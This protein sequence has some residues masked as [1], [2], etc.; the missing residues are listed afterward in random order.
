MRALHAFVASGLVFAGLT[1]SA[2]AAPLDV[3]ISNADG[4]SASATYQPPEKAQKQWRIGILIPHLKDTYWLAAAF[5][6]MDEAQR[7]GI[8]AKLVPAQG[9]TDVTGQLNQIDNLVVEQVDA[10]VL[11]AV[12]PQALSQ[13]VDQIVA[14]GIPVIGM[15][16]P[17]DSDAVKAR[18]GISYRIPAAAGGAYLAKLVGD[19]NANVA[20][21]PG[22]AGSGWAEDLNQ[23]FTDAVSS[24][25][26]IKVIDVKWGD[27]GKDVQ[28]SLLQNTLQAHPDVDFVI[29][30]PVAAEAAPG[31]LANMGLA[32]KV[33]VISL[34]ATPQVM[35]F[36]KSGQI[37][38]VPPDQAAT[39]ARLAV[40]AAVDT[41]ESRQVAPQMGTTIVSVTT[42][43]IGTFNS[44]ST[45][46]P[47]GY[48]PVFQVN[49]H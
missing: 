49:W 4:T 10:I 37:L 15:I 35:D 44:T 46:A 16:N 12:G 48:Q 32:D 9:Y 20:I 26:N 47:A 30:N 8:S 34:I 14:G 6:A 13:K 27:T 28:L 42:E 21:F 22:P 5:G 29:C 23:G 39:L 45:F 24:K 3:L 36:V 18:R 40:D 41:L 19:S 31:L 7:L 25:A 11:A 38:M 33:K 17:I 2:T 1:A 43:N